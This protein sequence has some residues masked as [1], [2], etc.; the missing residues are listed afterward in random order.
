MAA[1]DYDIS[2]GGVGKGAAPSVRAASFP[3]SRVIDFSDEAARDGYHSVINSGN[4]VANDEVI[5]ALAIPANCL[6]ER[7]FWEVESASDTLTQFDIGDDT[8]DDGWVDGSSVS[9][10]ATST[11]S[12]HSDS[13][14]GGTAV[15]GK[16]YTAANQVRLTPKTG[17][18]PHKTGRIRVTAIIT[19]NAQ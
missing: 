15:A 16:Y 13:F 10:D 2:V 4:G 19:P 5:K 12:G 3:L 17:T 1:A 8:D 11:G 6:V 7:V 14:V 18:G 9:N